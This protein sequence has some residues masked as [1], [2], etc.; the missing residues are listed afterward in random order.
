[1]KPKIIIHYAHIDLIGVH[2]QRTINT[3]RC[4]S[5]CL[6]YD[7]YNLLKT[8]ECVLN[9]SSDGSTIYTYIFKNATNASVTEIKVSSQ[10]MSKVTKTFI[11]TMRFTHFVKTKTF[12]K[13]LFYCKVYPASKINY[14]ILSKYTWVHTYTILCNNA[15][16]WL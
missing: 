3:N 4:A 1:M 5:V 10:L 14:H 12:Y 9:M 2:H 13:W 16:E 8:S 6:R 7:N 15:V 11:L